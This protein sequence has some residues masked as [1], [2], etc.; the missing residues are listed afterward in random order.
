MKISY[1]EESN[2]R[3][4][5]ARNQTVMIGNR[6]VTEYV[7]SFSISADVGCPPKV[8]ITFYPDEVEFD[9][10]LI[11]R[12]QKRKFTRNAASTYSC[13]TV[14]E[15]VRKARAIEMEVIMAR[16]REKAN[17]TKAMPTPNW[18]NWPEINPPSSYNAPFLDDV[19]RHARNLQEQMIALGDAVGGNVAEREDARVVNANYVPMMPIGRVSFMEDYDDPFAERDDDFPR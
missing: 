8:T 10:E 9:G 3:N 14:S 19:V 7:S 15:T 18:A 6:D 4:G 1:S 12:T 2:P 13:E 17:Q 5:R 16:Q 11:D